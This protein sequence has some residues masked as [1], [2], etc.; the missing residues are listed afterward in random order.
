MD[1]VYPTY[2]NK[3][4][5]KE[6]DCRKTIVIKQVLFTFTLHNTCVF[7]LQYVLPFLKQSFQRLRGSRGSKL[8]SNHCEAKKVQLFDSKKLSHTIK[9]ILPCRLKLEQV[10][11]QRTRQSIRIKVYE[12]T[13][14][15]RAHLEKDESHTPTVMSSWSLLGRRTQ[16]V[17]SCL[18][19]VDMMSDFLSVESV[20]S[21]LLLCSFPLSFS[22]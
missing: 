5:K 20:P 17:L 14:L 12:S 18:M 3:R 2:I 6:C 11:R 21:E 16:M 15:L 13:E 9:N 7:P 4:H 22:L 19:E 10:E 1:R 8:T